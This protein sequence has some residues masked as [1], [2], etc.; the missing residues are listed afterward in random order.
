VLTTRP[1]LS[2]RGEP[3]KRSS[4][5]KIGVVEF[6]SRGFGPLIDKILVDFTITVAATTAKVVGHFGVRHG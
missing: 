5:V 2:A 3:S 4:R 1:R 6:D